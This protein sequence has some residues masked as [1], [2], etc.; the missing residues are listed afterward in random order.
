MCIRD[1]FEVELTRCSP[2]QAAVIVPKPLFERDT[3]LF[4]LPLQDCFPPSVVHIGEHDVP[5]SF[6]MAAMIAGFCW[7]SRRISTRCSNCPSWATWRRSRRTHKHPAPR[8]VGEATALG[9]LLLR[10]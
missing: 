3:F 6:V 5:E 9:I 10:P 1:R 2:V 4:F 8:N 7:S